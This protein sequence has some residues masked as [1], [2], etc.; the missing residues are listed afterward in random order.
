MTKP[1]GRYGDRFSRPEGV[2]D[3]ADECID[4]AR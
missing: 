3:L 2:G 1:E 4:A